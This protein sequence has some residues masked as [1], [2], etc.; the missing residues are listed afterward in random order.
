MI[1][2]TPARNHRFG[3]DRADNRTEETVEDANPRIRRSV[4][5]KT[6]QAE[7]DLNSGEVILIEVNPRRRGFNE[8]SW[9]I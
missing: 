5:S 6:F 9:W 8:I 3:T 1:R 4:R 7:T 2:S